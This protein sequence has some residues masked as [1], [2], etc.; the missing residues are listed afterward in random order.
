MF[1]CVLRGQLELPEEIHR[2]APPP[3]FSPGA[4]NLSDGR[5]AS[6][7]HVTLL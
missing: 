3:A 5:F 4:L 6:W 2:G 7:A 1:R